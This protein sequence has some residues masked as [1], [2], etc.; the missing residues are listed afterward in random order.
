MVSIYTITYN[1]CNYQEPALRCPHF[2]ETLRTGQMLHCFQGAHCKSR[3]LWSGHLPSP[4]RH[5]TEGGTQYH[6]S[7]G[8]EP[9]WKIIEQVHVRMCTINQESLDKL[10]LSILRCSYESLL[11][12]YIGC[13]SLAISKI[14]QVIAV[15]LWRCF[16]VR[17][18]YDGKL[19]KSLLPPN[20]CGG[21][22]VKAMDLKSIGVSPRRFESCPQR[23]S[24]F[25]FY[26][27]IKYLGSQYPLWSKDLVKDVF[28]NMQVYSTERVIQEVDFTV[29][30][31]GPCQIHSLLLASTQVEALRNYLQIHHLKHNIFPT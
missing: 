15:A 25:F 9:A 8:Y 19:N 5:H 7:Q 23:S 11:D 17:V 14:G 18:N 2:D 27:T 26:F 3:P 24:T 6:E 30:I 4:L 28:S 12:Y 22:V 29:L 10:L 21:R 20:S 1:C 31:H 13:W 16:I